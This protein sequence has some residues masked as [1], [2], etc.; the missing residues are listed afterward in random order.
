MV[1]LVGRVDVE[2]AAHGRVGGRVHL[3]EVSGVVSNIKR[4]IFEC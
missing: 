1:L 4:A 2:A 3:D